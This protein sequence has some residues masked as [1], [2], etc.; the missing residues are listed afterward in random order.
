[1]NIYRIIILLLLSHLAYAK[2]AVAIFAG[3]N[4]WRMEAE[5]S[6]INGVLDVVT[7]FDGG[8]IK[9]PTYDAV[10]GNRTDYTQAVRVIY[11]PE[12]V[13]YQSILDYYWRHIDPTEKHGQ[14]CDIG[15]QYRSAIFYLNKQQKEL[16][17]AS[18]K[19]LEKKFKTVYTQVVPST[20]FYAADG[21][22]QGYYLNHPLK[23][24]YYLYRCGNEKRIKEI[25]QNPG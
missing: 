18:K 12:I 6:K 15:N 20:Q 4:F 24:R 9:N 11:N 19:A 10:I 2:P 23:F 5:F 3:G 16:A 8:T 1:M 7:G 17:L 25:W 22:Q 14:F 13:T 21:E